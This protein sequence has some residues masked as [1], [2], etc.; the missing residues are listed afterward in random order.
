MDPDVLP[1]R[2]NQHVCIIRP[3]PEIPVRYIHFHLL[4]PATKRF[5]MGI[6]AGASRQAVTK[7]HI[8]SVPLVIPGKAVLDIFASLVGPLFGA[9]SNNKAQSRS[10]AS[11]RDALLPRLISGEL[12]VQ[13]AERFVSRGGA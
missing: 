9:T 1:A 10:L 2:V 12:R 7:G 13:D 4:Q 8:E 11:M 5:L 6:D 3:K